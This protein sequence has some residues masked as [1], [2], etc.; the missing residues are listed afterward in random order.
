[1]LIHVEYAVIK[2]NWFVNSKIRG[3]KKWLPLGGVR[4]IFP[5]MIK[6]EY[7]RYSVILLKLRS[8]LQ[9]VDECLANREHSILA[10]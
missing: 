7:L 8:A 4:R 1:M 5:T 9:R 3:V 10:C 6:E 2:L